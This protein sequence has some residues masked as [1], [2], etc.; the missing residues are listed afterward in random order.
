[1]LVVETKQVSEMVDKP[2]ISL[3]KKTA[4]A[5]IQKKR[6]YTFDYVPY[7]KQIARTYNW[8]EL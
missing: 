5:F 3:S 1:M 7:V 8:M 4:D 2:L 6:V